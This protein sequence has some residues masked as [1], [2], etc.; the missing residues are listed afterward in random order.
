MQGEVKFDKNGVRIK[1]TTE[2]YQYTAG[3]LLREYNTQ[4]TMMVYVYTQSLCYSLQV[5][6]MGLRL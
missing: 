3:R 4:P 5:K 1:T 2:I 6:A